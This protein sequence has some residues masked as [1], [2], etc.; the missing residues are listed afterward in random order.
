[1]KKV[2]Q[3]IDFDALSKYLESLSAE[4]FRRYE[5]KETGGY[6]I[7]HPCEKIKN[8]TSVLD[9]EYFK[10]DKSK[11]PL[12]QVIEVGGYFMTDIL[13]NDLSVIKLTNRKYK[14]PGSK[15]AVNAKFIK[16]VVLDCHKTYG[17]AL[18]G[19]WMI[20]PQFIS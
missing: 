20:P 1:M 3:V 16:T 18:N 11:I 14:V 17:T 7:T 5:D 9:I 13:G 10:M 12:D 4:D 6:K 19:Y 2:K 8:G 15:Y